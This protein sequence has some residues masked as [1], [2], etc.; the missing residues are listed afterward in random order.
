MIY[1][2]FERR[3]V[4]VWSEARAEAWARAGVLFSNMNVSCE[5]GVM[6]MQREYSRARGDVSL[7]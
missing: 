5:D 4:N 6:A 3:R 1:F 7:L 2:K